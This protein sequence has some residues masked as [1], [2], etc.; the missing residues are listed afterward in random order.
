MF[1]NTY[2]SYKFIALLASTGGSACVLLLLLSR[3]DF[4]YDVHVVLSLLLLLPILPL[5]QAVLLLLLRVVPIFLHLL[6]LAFPPPRSLLLLQVAVLFAPFVD[7][8]SCHFGLMSVVSRKP[9]DNFVH[10]DQRST[11]HILCTFAEFLV[12]CAKHL[13]DVW[14]GGHVAAWS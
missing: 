3:T 7:V 6:F 4:V 9:H 12:S 1:E 11:F 13:C 14:L 2:F 8:A 5:L 10:H